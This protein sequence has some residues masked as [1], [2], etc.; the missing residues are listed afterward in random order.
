MTDKELKS[1]RIGQKIYSNK[2]SHPLVVISIRHCDDLIEI[3]KL[4]CADIHG[5]VHNEDPKEI[6]RDFEVSP[7]DGLEQR[8]LDFKE[9]NKKAQELMKIKKESLL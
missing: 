2:G 9:C 8:K 6:M 1:L 4:E 5:T 3:K 7:L